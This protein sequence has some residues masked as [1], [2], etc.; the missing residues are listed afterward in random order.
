MNGSLH[1]ARELRG[2]DRVVVGDSEVRIPFAD[3]GYGIE[4]SLPNDLAAMVSEIDPL[5]PAYVL[6]QAIRSLE[7]RLTEL[8]RLARSEGHSWAKVGQALGVARQ[9]AW[10]KYSG[11]E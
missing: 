4:I 6:A 2:Y 7:S 8:V 3:R 5:I 11:D 9:T 10:E 1:W